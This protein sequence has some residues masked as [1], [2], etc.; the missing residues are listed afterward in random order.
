MW[1]IQRLNREIKESNRRNK[2]EGAATRAAHHNTPDARSM[3]GRH[4]SMVPSGLR[5]FT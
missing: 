3:M 4:R 5:R 1:F 2:G